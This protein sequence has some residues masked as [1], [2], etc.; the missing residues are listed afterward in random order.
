MKL[1]PI[2]LFVILIGALLFSS[3]KYKSLFE[4]MTVNTKTTS[5]KID[6]NTY[7]GPAGDT[8]YV[9]KTP[10]NKN[11]SNINIAPQDTSD[12]YSGYV[13]PETN[14]IPMAQITPGDEDLYI[15]KSQ[16]VP[17]SCPVGQNTT[18]C[19]SAVPPQPCP[20]C[21]RCPEPAFDCKKVP[22]YRSTNDSYLP[23]PILNDFSS[24]GM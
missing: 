10:T 14:G 22:N 8:V 17:P 16:I 21:A 1:Y 9:Y 5:S 15:L 6:S 3:I 13:P 19:P 18:T 20:P 2:H 7:V 11:N 24:F 23:R 12:N 4:N